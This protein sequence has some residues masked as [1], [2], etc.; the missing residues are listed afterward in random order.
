MIHVRGKG[1]S[2][3]LT[4]E[5]VNGSVVACDFRSVETI[6]LGPNK[7]E[8]QLSNH[9]YSQYSNKNRNNQNNKYN[10]QNKPK[11]VEKAPEVKMDSAPADII[12]PS[13]SQIIKV[14]NAVLP[15]ECYLAQFIILS[16]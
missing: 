5:H 8:S 16:Q 13:I 2:R 3:E 14:I 4:Y 10:N 6:N 12:T 15:L 1:H 11:Q 9:N 7:E